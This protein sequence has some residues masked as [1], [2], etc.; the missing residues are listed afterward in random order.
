MVYTFPG[1]EAQKEEMKWSLWSL[2][3]NQ[4]DDLQV[5]DHGDRGKGL[6][7]SMKTLFKEHMEKV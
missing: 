6:Y 5:R 1:E 4:T 2:I 3:F 7:A